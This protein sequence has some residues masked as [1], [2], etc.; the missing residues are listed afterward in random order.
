MAELDHNKLKDKGGKMTK[1]HWE[2]NIDDLLPKQ[3]LFLERYALTHEITVTDAVIKAVE[4]LQSYERERDLERMRLKLDK[5]VANKSGQ[6][7]GVQTEQKKQEKKDGD[8]TMN[9]KLKAMRIEI[10]RDLCTA[11]WK[12]CSVLTEQGQ[13]WQNAT[14]TIRKHESKPK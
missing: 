8:Q 7:I 10:G 2:I 4:L 9:E 1:S 6:T 11:I 5:E 12:S 3:M 13:P 14:E